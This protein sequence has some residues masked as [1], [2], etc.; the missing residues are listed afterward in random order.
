M[1]QIGSCNFAVRYKHTRG[2]GRFGGCA[3]DGYYFILDQSWE[4]DEAEEAD[5]VDL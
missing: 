3:Y 1:A 2:I 4:G 5:G